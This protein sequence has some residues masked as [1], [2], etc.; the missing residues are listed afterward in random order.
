MHKDGK[1]ARELL[2]AQNEDGSWGTYFHTLSQPS[3]EPYTFEQALRRLEIL[4]F[5][6]EDAPIQRALAHM[7]DCL[8]GRAELADRRE[9]SHDWDTFIRLMLATWIRRFTP[10][11]ANA[12]RVAGQW[13]GVIGAA[14]SG[15]AY[16]HKRYL[17]AFQDILGVKARGGRF[18]DFV[19]F[20]QVSL[21]AGALDAPT[22]ALAFDYIFR[23]A[24]GIYYIYDFAPGADGFATLPKDFRSKDALRYL[25]A[26][27]LLS[28]YRGNVGKLR[29]VADWLEENRNADGRWDMGPAVRDGIRFPLSDSWRRREDRVADCTWWIEG[30]VGRLRG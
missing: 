21:L 9:V 1:W 4:G 30:L 2:E 29:F 23:H 10:C 22:E 3:Q 19:S 16:D 17:E 5:T 15:G 6:M 25:N 7:D 11:N 8:A 14:F 26:I 20:Y 13:V 27:E 12:N 28:A 18:L 24:P